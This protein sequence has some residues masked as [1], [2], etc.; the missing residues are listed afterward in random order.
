M[1]Y[2]IYTATSLLFLIISSSSFGQK[3]WTGADDGFDW[4]NPNNWVPVGT[5]AATDDVTIPEG[6]LVLIDGGSFTINDLT[7]EST[8][9]LITEVFVG[10]ISST[11]LNVNGNLLLT[12]SN[13]SATAVSSEVELSANSA[14]NIS[15]DLLFR[16]NSCRIIIDGHLNVSQNVANQLVFLNQGRITGSGR[17]NFNGS[18]NQFIRTNFPNFDFENLEIW[19][20]NSVGV[21]ITTQPLTT[22]QIEIQSGAIFSSNN[23]NISVNGGNFINSGTFTHG[24]SSLTMQGG[25]NSSIEGVSEI[26]NL[27]IEKNA[28]SNTVTILSS[29]DITESLS[30]IQGNLNTNDNISLTSTSTATARISAVTG[31]IS[32]NV[33]QQRFIN[34]PANQWFEIASPVGGT[35]MQWQSSGLIFT[36]FTGSD[37]PT[38]PTNNAYRYNP[39]LLNSELSEGWGDLANDDNTNATNISNATNRGQ[40]WKIFVAGGDYAIESTGT[41]LSGSATMNLSYNSANAFTQNNSWNLVGNPFCSPI[42]WV[43]VTRNNVHGVYSVYTRIGPNNYQYNSFDAVSNISVNGDGQRNIASSQGFWVRATGTNPSL[44]IPQSAKVPS[45]NYQR[46]DDEENPAKYFKLFVS[47]EGNNLK[48]EIAI[49]FNENAS[50]GHDEF[51]SPKQWADANNLTEL[52]IVTESTANAFTY[53]PNALDQNTLFPIKVL[54]KQNNQIN[55]GASEFNNMDELGI[56]LQ[57]FDIQESVILPIDDE[58]EYSTQIE[59]GTYSDRFYLIVG[60]GFNYESTVESCLGL[61]NGSIFIDPITIN[62]SINVFDNDNNLITNV[63]S[64][65][66][67]NNLNSGF[68]TIQIADDAPYCAGVSKTVHLESGEEVKSLFYASNN[69]VTLGENPTVFFANASENYSQHFWTVEGELEAFLE[70]NLIYTFTEPGLFEISLTITNG[71]EGCEDIYTE[72]IEVLPGNTTNIRENELTNGFRLLTKSQ[73]DYTIQFDSNSPTPT[74]ISMYNISGQLIW[75]KNNINSNE[76]VLPKNLQSGLYVIE[77][78]SEK[79]KWNLKVVY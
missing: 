1:K 74:N 67:L 13:A 25:G 31:N 5:P 56:C 54:V 36:G 4:N 3:T 53:L 20:S 62:P 30:V 10:P 72:V 57:F 46:N 38:F 75:N 35:L 32:G 78:I 68:Y 22:R 8:A 60:S 39:S 21:S 49:V 27:I 48:D 19:V 47:N 15:G 2:F 66:T 61:G 51:D 73:G 77:M 59:A 29:I 64:A 18:S 12:S 6:S 65:Q 34:F 37:F 52:A 11:T 71:F 42:D 58:F 26:S 33:T 17:I 41:P 7:I 63:S 24:S 69:L 28:A 16:R 79:N 43:A 44:F 70:E 23:Q 9:S 14:I 76:I 50:E 45:A 55:F 40:G